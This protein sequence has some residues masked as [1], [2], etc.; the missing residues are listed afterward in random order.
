MTLN[1]S[2]GRFNVRKTLRFEMKPLGKTAENLDA[3][4]ADDEDRASSLNTV[5]T[6]IE[7][8]HLALVRRVFNALPDPLPGYSEIKHSFRRDP[9]YPV[10]SERGTASVV[11]AMIER[12][13][14]TRMAVP[15]Q[16]KDLERWQ[17]LFIKWHWH[18][19]GLYTDSG[20]NAVAREWAGRAK[21]DVEATSRYLRAR[22]RQKPSRNY[23]FDHAPF[24]MMFD[25]HSCGM[26]WLKEDFKY[27]H[28]FLVKDGGDRILVG[29]TP[30]SSKV[31]PFTMPKP[32]PTEEAYFLYE[33]SADEKPHFRAIPRALVDAPAH[34]GSLF[35]FELCGRGLRNKSNLNAMYLRA[36]LSDNNVKDRV[37]HLDRVCEF[38]VR[39]G[40]DI[41][42]DGKPAH[43]RQRFT[44]DKFFVTLHISCNPDL[45]LAGNRP[46]AFGN[47]DKFYQSE[48]YAKFITVAPTD[49]GYTVDGEFVSTSAANN[50]VLAG[51]LARLVVEKDAYVLIDPAV[52]EA[53]RRGVKD[54]FGYIVVR[55]REP[56][57]DGGIM[58]GYQLVD[59]IFAGKP[60][61]LKLATLGRRSRGAAKREAAE[62]AAAERE[63]KAAA[64][65]AE[66]A[67]KRAYAEEQER[68]AAE[69][70]AARKMVMEDGSAAVFNAPL[71]KT[72]RFEFKFGYKTSDNT[73]HEAFCH[74]DSKDDV[75]SKLRTVGVRPYRVECDDPEFANASSSPASAP[76]LGIADRLK[77][78]N[79]LKDEG[80]LSDEEYAA[81]RA[82]IISEL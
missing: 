59:R 82:K 67:A 78:L 79:A 32:L 54:K 47:L 69:K 36:L 76:V 6:L 33:E 62:K 14:Q 10:L 24:R 53:I 28:T 40:A 56:Y 38:Y 41:P 58:R 20:E 29:I 50:G 18:C 37:F 55:G 25:N 51:T 19:L 22:K 64:K 68:K 16:L 12:C 45:V 57:T 27:S 81:Q 75:Y 21:A 26:G 3:F 2:I 70:K 31:N 72:G 35:L 9:A 4:L 39:K 23:W 52:P 34:H 65:A 77:R 13:R 63:A 17:P 80:L 43:F 73:R 7:A 42:K 8:E 46:Q 74:G 71:F 48:P 15:K 5:K 1:E 30:R 61:D 11:K 49:G 60:E 66:K 44:E